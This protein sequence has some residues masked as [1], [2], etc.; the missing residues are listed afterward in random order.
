MRTYLARRNL[1]AIEELT[2][3]GSTHFKLLSSFVR[4]QFFTATKEMNILSA[5][6]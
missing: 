6:H 4:S 1:S 5:A 2:K 3:M